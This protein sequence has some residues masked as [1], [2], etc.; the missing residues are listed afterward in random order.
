MMSLFLRAK[1]LIFLRIYVLTKV[2]LRPRGAFES[3]VLGTLKRFLSDFQICLNL[4]FAKAIAKEKTTL[5]G[6]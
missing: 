1:T 3:A 4:V 6:F 5:F 2:N